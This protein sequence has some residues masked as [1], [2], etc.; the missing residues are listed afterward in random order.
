MTTA[1]QVMP[2]EVRNIRTSDGQKW[3]RSNN[4]LS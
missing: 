4:N 1:G 3:S 2:E